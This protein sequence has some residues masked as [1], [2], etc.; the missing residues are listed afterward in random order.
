MSTYK[1]RKI[2]DEDDCLDNTILTKRC[3]N[4]PN[5]DYD[6]YFD[7]TNQNVS[8]IK[9]GYLHDA[10]KAVLYKFANIASY[11]IEQL[12]SIF[13][14]LAAK[15]SYF[16]TV[17]VMFSYLD[18]IT[19]IVYSLTKMSFSAIFS[20]HPNIAG[21]VISIAVSGFIGQVLGA[22]IGSTLWPNFSITNKLYKIITLGTNVSIAGVATGTAAAA[23]GGAWYTK[24]VGNLFDTLFSDYGPKESMPYFFKKIMLAMSGAGLIFLFYTGGIKPSDFMDIYSFI[25]NVTASQIVNTSF[26][27]LKYYG[28]ISVALKM[29]KDV[30]DGKYKQATQEGLIVFVSNLLLSG[31]FWTSTATPTPFIQTKGLPDASYLNAFSIHMSNLI[32]KNLHL[33]SEKWSNLAALF[34]QILWGTLYF[35]GATITGSLVSFMI[36]AIVVTI[37]IWKWHNSKTKKLQKTVN[38][39]MQVKKFSRCFT[40]FV[41]LMDYCVGKINK[42]KV[43]FPIFEMPDD[44]PD[45]MY[46]DLYH[47]FKNFKESTTNIKSAMLNIITKIKAV[48]TTIVNEKIKFDSFQIIDNYTNF[49]EVKFQVAQLKYKK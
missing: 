8:E 30:K 9:R 48:A 16:T 28:L 38:E 1:K 11:G 13:G 33:V 36:T 40:H 45:S 6:H 18:G 43:P 41:Q 15:T 34:G 12:M 26:S 21:P 5:I 35:V 7:S 49:I 37:L 25:S 4:E 22:G 3:L 19:A 10:F 20:L 24:R 42:T 2:S 44:E 17:S 46:K 27:I 14:Y 31:E 29:G 23:I 32:G 47:A 39:E